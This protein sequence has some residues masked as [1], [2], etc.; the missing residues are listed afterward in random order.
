LDTKATR[1]M[2]I[3]YPHVLPLLSRLKLVFR[4]D[5]VKNCGVYVGECL[6][7]AYSAT[8]DRKEQNGHQIFN[9]LYQGDCISIIVRNDESGKESTCRQT[10]AM[11]AGGSR[12]VEAPPKI[13]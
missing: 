1:Q 8:H 13:A 7:G 4:P 12:E 9:L 11:D 6:T 3:V 2:I 10:S 5:R